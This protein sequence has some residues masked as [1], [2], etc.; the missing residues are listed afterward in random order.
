MWRDTRSPKTWL[1]TISLPAML[2]IGFICRRVACTCWM[3]RWIGW[4]ADF[5]PM[6]VYGRY[7]VHLSSA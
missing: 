3:Y 1:T 5:L 2:R 4:R 7:V 6:F